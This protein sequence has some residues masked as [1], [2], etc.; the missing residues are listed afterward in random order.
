MEKYEIQMAVGTGWT[1]VRTFA[2]GTR[3]LEVRQA[4]G[5]LRQKYSMW[6]TT[7]RMVKWAATP[8]RG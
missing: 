6:E 1:Q 8:L 3:L 2:P 7:F 5:R 4:L